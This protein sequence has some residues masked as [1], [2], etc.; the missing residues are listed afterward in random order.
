MR[1]GIAAL[2]GGHHH[3]FCGQLR[4]RHSA[5]ATFRWPARLRA[6][7]SAAATANDPAVNIVEDHPGRDRVELRRSARFP[8]SSGPAT[9]FPCITS[10]KLQSGV[11]RHRRRGV[12]TGRRQDH[13]YRRSRP[14]LSFRSSAAAR[15]A[16]PRPI[17]PIELSSRTSERVGSAFSAVRAQLP[18]G[19]P[20]AHEPLSSDGRSVGFDGSRRAYALDRDDNSRLMLNWTA[21]R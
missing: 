3:N 12:H 4:C 21:P 5:R 9:R 16:P 7:S 8:T 1:T 17:E 18:R 13:Q 14:E 11:L 2:S 20:E 15:S 19:R 10:C 6:T